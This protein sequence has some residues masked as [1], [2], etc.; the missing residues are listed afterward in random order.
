MVH[1]LLEGLEWVLACVGIDLTE[2]RSSP[3]GITAD[4]NEIAMSS[5]A[6]Q[7]TGR[8]EGG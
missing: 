4:S 8:R 7:W 3:E 2:V 1:L 5:L 6:R